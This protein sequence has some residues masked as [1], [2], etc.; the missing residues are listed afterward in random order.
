MD[1]VG[2]FS[3]Q[4]D[5]RDCESASGPERSRGFL[6]H[7]LFVRREV[8]HAV[9]DDDIYRLIGDREVFDLTETELYVRRFILLD[10]LSGLFDHFRRHID[11]DDVS[12]VAN[13]LRGEEAIEACAG[14]EIQNGLARLQRGD[15]VRISTA[16]SQVCSVGD[17]SLLVF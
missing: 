16:E 4:N 1:I 12:G 5:V 6:E 17:G 13:F 10:V 2:Q 9:R 15:C 7:L 8:Y 11:A 3:G 14:A